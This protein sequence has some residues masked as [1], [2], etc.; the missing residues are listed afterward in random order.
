MCYR[1]DNIY[2]CNREYCESR[3]WTTWECFIYCYIIHKERN[4]MFVKEKYTSE[5]YLQFIYRNNNLNIENILWK[6]ECN[7]VLGLYVACLSKYSVT[8]DTKWQSLHVQLITLP[9]LVRAVLRWLT[10]YTSQIIH[11][12]SSIH[13]I[14]CSIHRKLYYI[15]RIIRQILNEKNINFL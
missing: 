6:T 4:V 10:H 9:A 1:S 11:I 5:Q 12:Q 13:K 3:N 7:R 14:L 15:S 8:S 2:F